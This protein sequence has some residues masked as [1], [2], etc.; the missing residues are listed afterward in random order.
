MIELPYDA[1]LQTQPSWCYWDVRDRTTQR[2]VKCPN[3]HIGVLDH[4]VDGQGN[5]TPSVQC[6][7][8]GCTFHEMVRLLPRR[9]SGT[10]K[11]P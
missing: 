1:K 9:V 10:N 5:V 8:E 7:Q 11:G 4:D 3:G 6:P 2:M